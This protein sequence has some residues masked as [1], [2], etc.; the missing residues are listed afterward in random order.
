MRGGPNPWTRVSRLEAAGGGVPAAVWAE[1]ERVA[2]AL[3]LDP[4]VLLAEAEALVV[5]CR[6]AGAVTPRQQV[7]MVA[8]EDGLDPAALWAVAAE[9]D[10]DPTTGRAT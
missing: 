10:L 9:L 6:E 3:G 1:A 8:A 7:E 4:R 5:H 2:L